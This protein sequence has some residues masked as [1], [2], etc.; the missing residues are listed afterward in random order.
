MQRLRPVVGRGSTHAARRQAVVQLRGRRWPEWRQ[1]EVLRSHEFTGWARPAAAR[2]WRRWARSSRR[3]A[4]AWPGRNAAC[5]SAR[6]S[7]TCATTCWP[8]GTGRPRRAPVLER[9]RAARRRRV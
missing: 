3:P 8:A 1:H 2:R 5:R 6:R 7:I 9:G 4:G